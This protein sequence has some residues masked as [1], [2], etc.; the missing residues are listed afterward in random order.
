MK[1]TTRIWRSALLLVSFLN[2]VP[3]CFGQGAR[4]L[5][6]GVITDSSGAVIPG[7]SVR[8]VNHTNNVSTPAQTN[9]D[10]S[11]ALDFLSPGEYTLTIESKGFKT[12]EQNLTVRADDH[13]VV[14]F[15]LDVGALS[16]KVLVE[17]TAQ[18]LDT[19]SGSLGTVIDN[20]RI[21]ELPEFAGNPFMLEFLTAGVVFN[22]TST[23]PN[24]RPFDGS[25]AVGSV[26]G[27]LT[28]STTFQL[29]GVPDTGGVPP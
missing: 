8:A 1:A 28:Y 18:V 3:Y 10:G 14:N 24:Q 17:G 9:A 25:A 4:E 19:G 27:S 5:V 11:Y 15:T 16:E 23:F 13:L 29:D 21:R 22:G 12:L 7:A 20:Q 26:N 2:V 6:T